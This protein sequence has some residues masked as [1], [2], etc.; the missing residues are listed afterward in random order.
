M[1][2]LWGRPVKMVGVIEEA[3]AHLP[4]GTHRRKGK[5]FLHAATSANVRCERAERFEN[6]NLQ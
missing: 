4:N 1:S 5:V 6:V 3:L 2:W